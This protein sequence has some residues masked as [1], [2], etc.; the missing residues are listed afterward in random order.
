MNAYFT[1]YSAPDMWTY[2]TNGIYLYATL[3]TADP[4][5]HY[6]TANEVSDPSYAK[7]WMGTPVTTGNSISNTQR[8]VFPSL[9]TDQTVTHVGLVDNSS[10]L[11]NYAQLPIPVNWKAPNKLYWNVGTLTFTLNVGA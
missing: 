10:H 1:N 6:I 2:L 8:I 5:P 11:I 9:T 4:K 3:F 7:Q